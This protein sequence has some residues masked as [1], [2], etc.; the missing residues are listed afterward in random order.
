MKNT[1]GADS[2]LALL[3]VFLFISA[4]LVDPTIPL[5]ERN[6]EQVIL[7]GPLR[8][9]V[10]ISRTA[11]L[12]HIV[13]Q[14][15]S[16]SQF[17]HAQ[18]G[19]YIEQKGEN[20]SSLE[21]E[22]LQKH[23]TLRK[24]KGWGGGLEQTFYTSL[25]LEAALKQGVETGRLSADQAALERQ[26]LTQFAPR[27]EKLM[28]EE[29]ETLRRFATRLGAEKESLAS[30]AEQTSAFFRKAQVSVPLYLI[31]NPDLRNCGG[32]YNG[33]RMTLEIPREYDIY[34]IFLHEVFHAFTEA[35]KPLLEKAV[36][37][38]P[39][40]DYETLNEGLAYAISPGLFHPQTSSEDPLQDEVIADLE[41]RKP[42]SD[43]YTRFRRFGLALRPLLEEAL[44][45]NGSSI[46]AFLPRA[47]DA[48]RVLRELD[49]A[50]AASERKPRVKTAFS[51]GPGWKTLTQ[52]VREKGFSCS[53]YNH[54]GDHY[55]KAFQ[56][57]RSDDIVVLLFTL[58]NEDRKMPEEFK[59]L[60]PRPW[61]EIESSLKEGKVVTLEGKAREMRTILIAAPT[62]RELEE[63]ILKSK[64]F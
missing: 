31:A 58:E 50:M 1:L 2:R 34:P 47:V 26:V 12:F 16:W 27:I 24:A 5:Q 15:S 3:P 11:H 64:S 48:W 44:G 59:D 63:A 62:E 61:A 51:F 53:S 41:A 55:R 37:R 22:L 49:S 42:L 18:Y 13:D 25:D 23:A 10:H 46:D 57:T 33:G 43:A 38:A 54:L 21:R 35:Q 6:P 39:G 52:K 40:L 30:F 32:G 8:I 36:L 19:R 14:L 20:L 7:T 29:E 28:K 9:D 45:E 4:A 17:C 56:K 60:L